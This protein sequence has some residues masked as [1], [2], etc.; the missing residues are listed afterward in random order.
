MRLLIACMIVFI[1]AQS[2]GTALS[3]EQSKPASD[4][5]L[6]PETKMT[7]DP[8]YT[9]GMD[10]D[11]DTGARA[12]GAVDVDVDQTEDADTDATGIDG[13][14]TSAGADSDTDDLPDT[15]GELPL[16]GLVGV[17]ALAMSLGLR[18]MFRRGKRA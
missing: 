16:I 5:T 2:T 18:L 1:G 17:L 13:T 6:E 12:E 4:M 8:E 10:V 9:E 7:L 11:V 15:A 3:Q 14:G